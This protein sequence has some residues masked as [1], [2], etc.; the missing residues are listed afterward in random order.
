MAALL[1]RNNRHTSCRLPS[2]SKSVENKSQQLYGRAGKSS[3]YRTFF[4]MGVIGPSPGTLKYKLARDLQ[5]WLGN[6]P[7]G[8]TRAVQ[9]LVHPVYRQAA[10][11]FV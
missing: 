4:M 6:E 3:A 8:R 2:I 5:S 10:S 9:V 11:Q 1:Q 7:T